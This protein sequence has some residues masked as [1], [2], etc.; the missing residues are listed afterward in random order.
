MSRKEPERITNKREHKKALMRL[1][2]LWSRHEKT[3]LDIQRLQE[4]VDDYE[5]RLRTTQHVKEHFERLE[6]LQCL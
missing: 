4:E 3:E 6:A 2:V 1:E 5:M